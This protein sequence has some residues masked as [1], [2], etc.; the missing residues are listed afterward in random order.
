MGQRERDGEGEGE[1]ER[2]N[3]WFVCANLLYVMQG[4]PRGT[5]SM[6]GWMAWRGVDKSQVLLLGKSINSPS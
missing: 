6:D 5:W 1:R 4:T 3:K 2:V